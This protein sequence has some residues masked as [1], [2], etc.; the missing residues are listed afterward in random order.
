M[1]N[2]SCLYLS[3]LFFSLSLN[4]AAQEVTHKNEMI[5]TGFCTEQ[6]LKGNPAISDWYVPGYME[7]IPEASAIEVLKEF[8]EKSV[9]FTVVM[10]IWCSDS[11]E[12]VPRFFKVIYDAGFG[13]A[14]VTMIGVDRK[15]Q[16]AGIDI[17]Y[18]KIEKVPTIIV[19]SD[20]VELGRIIETPGV[21]VEADLARILN[22]N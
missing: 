17:A 16:A 1:K 20:E 10:G 8:S 5:V 19:Y 18:Y 9:T 4:V 7:Y 2:L 3:L 6:D 13:Q 12:H 15:K 14:D 11:R 21:S 22:K